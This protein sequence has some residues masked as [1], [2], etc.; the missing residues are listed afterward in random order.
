MVVLVVANAIKGS[1]TSIVVLLTDVVVATVKV[2]AT[3]KSPLIVMRSAPLRV[4]K[5]NIP[6]LPEASKLNASSSLSIKAQTLA[7]AVV[8]FPF[9][10]ILVAVTAPEVLPVTFP[11]IGP[12]KP[13]AVKMPVP[14]L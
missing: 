11:V 4:S 14:A 2:P 1:A 5:T 12:A 13:V 6:V 8:I 3:V 7:A 9:R 10:A